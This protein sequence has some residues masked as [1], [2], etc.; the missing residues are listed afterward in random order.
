MCGLTVR[1]AILLSVTDLRCVINT[2]S[3]DAVVR[4]LAPV[5]FVRC[6]VPCHETAAASAS[7]SFSAE[8]SNTGRATQGGA[9]VTVH[10]VLRRPLNNRSSSCSNVPCHERFLVTTAAVIR[11]GSRKGV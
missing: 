7:V 11:C 6:D 3:L 1:L 9:D 2:S 4:F 5:V 10:H 8:Y